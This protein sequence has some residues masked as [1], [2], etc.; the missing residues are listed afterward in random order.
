MVLLNSE[1]TPLGTEIKNF[2]LPNVDGGNFANKDLSKDIVVIVFICNH[3]PYVHEVMPELTELAR[4]QKSEVDF[5]A[6]SS[7]DP[8]YREEDSFENMKIFA[9]EN[10]FSFP[11]LFDESQA[12]ARDFGAVC[13]PELFTYIRKG[14]SEYKLAYHG[15]VEMLGQA[16]Q[17]LKNS[18]EVSFEQLPSCG[19]SIKWK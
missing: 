4:Q 3:C 14:D 8:D 19:C 13:T 16:L 17:D 12:V 1:Q 5:V 9:R 7:N 18:G 15:K 6:I 11:Y 2:D 10:G